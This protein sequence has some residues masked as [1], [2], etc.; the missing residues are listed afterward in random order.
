MSRRVSTE[1]KTLTITRVQPDDSGLYYCDGKPAAYLTVTEGEK[2]ERDRKP[3]LGLVLGIAS[4]FLLLFLGIIIIVIF[5]TGRCRRK[6]QGTEESHPVYEE[7]W[8]EVVRQPTHGVKSSAGTAG[9]Y[10]LA[11]FPETLKTNEA[12]H[13]VISNLQSGGKNKR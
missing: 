12:P 4:T 9:L 10:S 7:I 8:N 5:F 3:F 6:K 13:H 1:D 11:T 2:P